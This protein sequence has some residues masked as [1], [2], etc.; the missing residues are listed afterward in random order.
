MFLKARTKANEDKVGTNDQI[1]TPWPAKMITEFHKTF[2]ALHD[3]LKRPSRTV[4][5]I[6][7]TV[8]VIRVLVLNGSKTKR[9][10]CVG[11]VAIKL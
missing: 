6:R 9:V 7:V 5:V 3:K 11:S 4:E 2:R 8:E 10:D 1:R